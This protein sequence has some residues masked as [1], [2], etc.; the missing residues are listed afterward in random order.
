MCSRLINA[1]LISA[2]CVFFTVS[3]NSSSAGPSAKD[4]L[5]RYLLENYHVGVDPGTT[6]LE[7]G[8]TAVCAK[9][10]KFT[11]IATLNVWEF[12]SWKDS[13]LSWNPADY[14]GIDK[15][16]IPAKLVWTPDTRLYNSQTAFADRDSN[17][18]AVI[19]SDGSV[20]WIP[21]AT[22]RLHCKNNDGEAAC[23]I[24]I[25][26]WTYDGNNLVL[27]QHGPDGL[28]LS[29][30]DDACPSVIS[31]HK[32]EVVNHKYPC[33]EEPY[34]SLDVTLAITHRAD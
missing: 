21:P 5:T 7:F 3:V 19:T 1:V 27:K 13:R 14:S 16:R 25:G 9:F 28:D 15:L 26:S 32:A 12:H 20:L 10:D 34:P 6:D 18:N 8:V 30:Y 31:S 17:V 11:D 24:R 29:N 23:Q 33:C 4:R 2:A 22:Y